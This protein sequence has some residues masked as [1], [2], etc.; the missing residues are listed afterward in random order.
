MNSLTS[1]PASTGPEAA[2]VIHARVALQQRRQ[3]NGRDDT[4]RHGAAGHLPNGSILP[5]ASG[6]DDDREWWRRTGR[7]EED[8]LEQTCG[9]REAAGGDA[10]RLELFRRAIGE[11][12]EASWLTIVELYRGFL[13]AHAQRHFLRSLAGEDDSFCVDRAF[14]R[15][16]QA[17]RSGRHQQFN[18]L[19]SVLKYLMLCVSSVLLDEARARRRRQCLT[20]D[21]ELAD[22]CVSA[23]HSVRVIGRLARQQLWRAINRELIDDNERLV[24]HLYFAAGLSPREILRRHPRRFRTASDI[25]RVK[26]NMIERLRRNQTIRCLLVECSETDAWTWQTGPRQRHRITDV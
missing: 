26:R 21:V 6:G 8:A 17:T 5:E 18:D 23:D 7:A 16:W 4:N 15:F 14:E 12:D 9:P 13:I 2:Y 25:Y 24:A 10:R 1:N 3:T 11:G 20:L 19:A 22:G